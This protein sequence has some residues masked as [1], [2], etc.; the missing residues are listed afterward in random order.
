MT[1]LETLFFFLGYFFFFGLI[2]FRYLV[3]A[4]RQPWEAL[5]PVYNVYVMIRVIERPWWWLILVL[6]P[7]VGNVMM[8]VILYELLH[9]FRL[10]TLKN[11]LITI[12]TV[13]LYMAYLSFAEELQYQGRDI[14]HMRKHVSELLASIIFA[15]VAASI[16]RAYTFEAFT[17]PTPSMEKSLMV[18][19]FLFVSK[20]EYGVRMPL[21]PFAVPLVHNRL[22]FSE[23]NSYLDVPQLPYLRLPALDPIKRNDPV[24]FNYPAEDIRPINMEGELRP[25]DK[26]EHYV[27]RLI[28]MPGDTLAIR[29]G[30]VYI[31]GA[32][33]ELPDRARPQLSYLVQTN[34]V[35]LSR[36]VL[37]KEF[38]I[39][40]AQAVKQ[41]RMGN[42]A[43]GQMSP[44]LYLMDVPLDQVQALAK[45]PNVNR[46]E[47]YRYEPNQANPVFPNPHHTDS[48]V[49]DWSRDNYGP[50]LIPR[51][52]MTVA[53]NEDHYYKFHRL[54]TAYEGHRLKRQA[55]GGYLL[56][57]QPADSYTF[58]QD[59]YFMMGDNRHSSDDSRFWGYVPADHIVGKPVFI[60]M[61][62]D[63]Y[64][65]SL[66][67]RI[68]YER[69]FTLVSGEGERTS[70]FW[71]F[72]GLVVI[73]WGLNYY[74]KKRRG[75]KAQA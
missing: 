58:E 63:G 34:G 27:K 72:V 74:R 12:F 15:V 43:G 28:G 33:N 22:P 66:L 31:N 11:I 45:L 23:I 35:D 17:I 4:G 71:P 44:D 13:G 75:Q 9:V 69:V 65:D 64:A 32:P 30:E 48:L 70:Y 1:L 26:R 8:I 46:V 24:V 55:D 10:G 56:D 54:I 2:S 29:T 60:W 40:L 3:A 67:D 18:G 49:Y 47:P 16:I 61:S 39:N 37:K 41:R 14:K 6:L 25:I 59:Y 57:G 7:G 53:L 42:T 36:E 50:L 19:D 21:T 52:G 73:G 20:I 51:K 62:Y 68:R 38:N 5:L